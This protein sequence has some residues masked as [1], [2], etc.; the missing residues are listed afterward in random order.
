[1]RSV[2][3]QCQRS[4]QGRFRVNHLSLNNTRCLAVGKESTG[5]DE[6]GSSNQG[7][8][9]LELSKAT[10][11]SMVVITSAAGYLSYGGDLS[12]ITCAS[13]CAGTSFAA[14]TAAILNQTIERKTDKL[15]KRTCNRPLPSGRISTEGAIGYGVLS[16]GASYALL[17]YGTNDT[18]LFLGFSNIALYGAYT[19]A[20]PRTEWNTWAGAVV[21]AIPPVMG[22]TAAGGDLLALEPA[23][24]GGTLFLWQFPHFFALS[25][26][27]RKDYERGFHQMV[28]V[29]DPTGERTAELILKYSLFLLPVPILAAAAD[30]TSPYFAIGGVGATAYLISLAENFEKEKSNKNAHEVFKCSLWYLLVML[31]LFVFHRKRGEKKDEPLDRLQEQMKMFCPHEL[32]TT[33]GLESICPMTSKKDTGFVVVK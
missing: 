22:W 4:N 18:T 3:K 2:L 20:K 5:E 21:G 29:N 6:L 24:L 15:M 13:L 10:L 23:L 25:W 16:M 28:P 27:N 12:P 31:G 32:L 17:K 33:L 14:A 26:N 19:L 11:S 1:M 8:I 30:V 9:Y 7:K